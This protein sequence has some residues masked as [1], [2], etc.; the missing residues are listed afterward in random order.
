[1]HWL[2]RE[3][4]RD[5]SSRHSRS[6]AMF[7]DDSALVLRPTP[8]RQRNIPSADPSEQP[9]LAAAGRHLVQP[10]TST[11]A[12]TSAC[13]MPQPHMQVTNTPALQQASSPAHP[14]KRPVPAACPRDL[15][16][17]DL[18]A[19][20]NPV[21][22][23][24]RIAGTHNRLHGRRPPDMAFRQAASKAS[25]ACSA[26]TLAGVADR[27]STESYDSSTRLHHSLPAGNS[28]SASRNS[29]AAKASPA[30]DPMEAFRQTQTTPAMA[31]FH[32]RPWR[33]HTPA[34]A[35]SSTAS[36]AS[37][38][39]LMQPVSHPA[40]GAPPRLHD[41][42]NCNVARKFPVSGR[43]SP[44]ARLPVS[45]RSPTAASADQ[46]A[47]RRDCSQPAGQHG[48]AGKTCGSVVEADVEAAT[49]ADRALTL[50]PDPMMARGPQAATAAKP[51][52]M[53]VADGQPAR[54]AAGQMH[55]SNRAQ[56]PSRPLASALPCAGPQSSLPVRQPP[57]KPS[58]L[59]NHPAGSSSIS[60]AQQPSK[61]SLWGGAG[62]NVQQR[63][64]NIP[65]GQ[66]NVSPNS[67]QIDAVGTGGA[68]AQ[69]DPLSRP[70]NFLAYQLAKL[71]QRPK[72]PAMHKPVSS[73]NQ[74][75][76]NKLLEA[77]HS[78]IDS[79]GAAAKSMV[80][81][82][83]AGK[84][85]MTE[86]QGRSGHMH[87]ARKAGSHLRIGLSC[88]TDVPANQSM[89]S[90]R[91]SCP[92][93]VPSVPD[94]VHLQAASVHH[95]MQ[96][97]ALL[98]NFQVQLRNQQDSH[99]TCRQAQAASAPRNHSGV[100]HTTL[101]DA[102]SDID[103]NSGLGTRTHC[104]AAC[105]RDGP[106]H[107]TLARLT[108]KHT[109]GV[110]SQQAV[111]NTASPAATC[112]GDARSQQAACIR[113]SSPEI[114]AFEGM[115]AVANSNSPAATSSAD[116]SNQGT[117]YQRA[118]SHE[119]GVSEGMQTVASAN[120]PAATS[121]ADASNQGTAYQRAGSPESDVS[122]GR[123]AVAGA[124][125]PAVTSSADAS[126]QGAAGRRAGS[127]EIGAFEGMQVAANA[128]SPAATSPADAS[129]QQTACRRASSPE[130]GECKGMQAVASATSPAATSSADASNEGTAR[131]T[132][133]SPQ[134]G[135]FEGM[136][137]VLDPSI[138]PSEAA[139]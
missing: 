115:Q 121:S 93:A 86:G 101:G 24:G 80:E 47:A 77:E 49:G 98:E 22:S 99:N 7:D 133:G 64:L 35:A 30:V 136:Q 127:R 25:E 91:L 111:L 33:V 62:D 96:S 38:A 48:R 84:R 20:P 1:M 27:T 100:V 119:S 107:S 36:A 13:S 39:K 92:Q 124:T 95:C 103:G 6:A 8:S 12:A 78:A 85:Q 83:F 29:T 74:Q 50:R 2:A 131:Q 122:E 72:A 87:A 17:A 67:L 125:S 43:A 104:E 23:S 16:H 10:T 65:G 110:L 81:G 37:S 132:A 120:S 123:Q 76:P 68:V 54:H 4:P 66:E 105:E 138:A 106:M 82:S 118:G 34:S 56:A 21:S 71:Q 75:P 102:A 109:D 61:L 42:T 51:L 53:A 79:A 97:K 9:L 60:S 14:A 139:R 40:A 130:R 11:H 58:A 26:P 129:P 134:R 88:S 18:P 112:S 135:V 63:L 108:S 28:S 59:L 57:G 126:S 41:W 44:D 117:A 69:Q 31:Y 3:S 89:Y 94:E 15:V 32:K 137:A 114:G 45:R 46:P 5:Q 70:V 128:A 90:A 113:A 52:Q 116:A 73:T 55:M 19:Q